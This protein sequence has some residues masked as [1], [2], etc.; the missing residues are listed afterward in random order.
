MAD[1]RVEYGVEDVDEEVDE[2]VG[3]GDDR[4]Q[5]L[6]RDVLAGVM[7]SASSVPMPGNEKITSITTAP[8]MSVP[9]LSP[10]TVSSV[11]LDGRRAC[12]HS[13][14]RGDA[15]GLRHGDEVLLERGDHVAAQQAHV[16]SDLAGGQGD[17]RQR[18]APECSTRSSLGAT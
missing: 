1:P 4:H 9:T 14:R 6:Q 8:P 17:D 7:A 5:A 13:T 2:H 11:R 12:R 15:L 3:H 16:G 10:A 18:H